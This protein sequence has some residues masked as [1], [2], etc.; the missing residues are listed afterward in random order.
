MF[1]S[2]W[3]DDVSHNQTISIERLGGGVF[4]LADF[5]VEVA[6]EDERVVGAHVRLDG[7][8]QSLVERVCSA[9]VAGCACLRRRVHIDDDE[10]LFAADVEA[11]DADAVA[12][13]LV[14]LRP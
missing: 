11:S 7:S 12:E 14:V 10:M 6:G 2:P 4:P 3:L 8:G 9:R 1:T 5:G 13:R